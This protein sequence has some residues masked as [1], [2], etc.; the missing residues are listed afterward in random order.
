MLSSR[1]RNLMVPCVVLAIACGPL[2]GSA[3]AD[4]I[5]NVENS[6]TSSQ[7]VL[8]DN[9]GGQYPEVTAVLRQVGTTNGLS[10][11]GLYSFL[12]NDG[13]GSVDVYGKMPTGSGYT[14][15][16]GNLSTSISGTYSPYHNIPEVAVPH[17]YGAAK[18]RQC[19]ARFHGNQHSGTV[20]FWD[21]GH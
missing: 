5:T 3:L 17:D 19:R 10:F 13:T 6:Y 12:V 2:A 15:T 9:T 20:E 4:S 7:T 16:A 18:F 14:P 21:G 11:I 1:M 8:L